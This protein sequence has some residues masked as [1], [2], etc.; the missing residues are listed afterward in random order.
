MDDLIQKVI[1]RYIRPDGDRDED[2]VIVPYQ[3]IMVYAKKE[4]VGRLNRSR[5]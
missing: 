4:G 2:P 3:D 1:K 5:W